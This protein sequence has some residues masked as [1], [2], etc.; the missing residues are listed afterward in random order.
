MSFLENA[1]KKLHAMRPLGTDIETVK[2]Q[3]EQLKELKAPMLIRKR[4]AQWVLH[5]I[6]QVNEELERNDIAQL[7]QAAIE[8]GD[9]NQLAVLLGSSGL[10]DQDRDEEQ[11]PFYMR[12]L[13][14]LSDVKRRNHD[15]NSNAVLSVEG[16]SFLY[17]E[18]KITMRLHH[19]HNNV[20]AVIK[21]QV[22][23]IQSLR[24]FP[25]VNSIKILFITDLV[26]FG[27]PA[28][29]RGTR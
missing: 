23:L 20:Y 10:A 24:N 7:I 17:K 29:T 25:K 6:A 27:Y 3:I 11:A 1:E 8:N 13:R 28:S 18:E 16:N 12:L 26:A 4:S 19:F 22:S 15:S 14:T 21:I 9:V 5:C 2:D